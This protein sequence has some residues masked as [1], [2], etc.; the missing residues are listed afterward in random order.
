MKDEV[1]S[2]G[3]QAAFPWGKKVNS[4]VGSTEASILAHTL[5]LAQLNPYQTSDLQSINITNLPVLNK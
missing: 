3:T 5:I 4:P 1:T 2:Q